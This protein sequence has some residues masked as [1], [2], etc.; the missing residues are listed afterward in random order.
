V[1]LERGGSCWETRRVQGAK[2]SAEEDATK[3]DGERR[4]MPTRDFRCEKVISEEGSKMGRGKSVGERAN[5]GEQ[6]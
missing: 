5:G 3:R 4:P 6:S 2:P 1:A